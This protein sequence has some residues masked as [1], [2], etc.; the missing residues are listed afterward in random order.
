HGSLLIFDEVITGF[1]VARGG[2]IERYA[3][4]PDLVVLGK[5][6]GGGLPVGAYGGR[7]DLMRLVAPDG[8]VYQAGT[9]SGNP[10][11]MAA[12][13]ATLRR[14]TPDL[15]EG[16][17]HTTAELEDGL[18]T[19]ARVAGTDVRISRVASLLTVFF[20]DDVDGGRFARFFHAMLEGGVMLPPSQH[21]AWF[22]SAA[23]TAHDVDVTVRAARGAFAAATVGDAGR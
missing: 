18:A 3:V 17:E 22:A 12:G 13:A 8:P 5:I 15:Y 23:H 19:A 2:A 9:L 6:I 4:T 21:E 1:R 7:A 11:A 20:K 16:L 14:L 10:L